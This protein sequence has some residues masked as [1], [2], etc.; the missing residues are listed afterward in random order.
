M[1]TSNS[2]GIEIVKGR[3]LDM[4]AARIIAAI[5]RKF[6]G[7]K[8]ER[9]GDDIVIEGQEPIDAEF[10]AATPWVVSTVREALQ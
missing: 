5:R 8:A 3:V 7:A 10:R 1:N 9:V 6:P 4:S 2:E